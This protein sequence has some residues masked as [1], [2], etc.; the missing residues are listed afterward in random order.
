MDQKLDSTENLIFTIVPIFDLL[1][2]LIWIL[3]YFLS[4]KLRD[5]P[6]DLFLGMI[7]GEMLLTIHWIESSLNNKG[8]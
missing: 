5:P 8:K 3:V 6:G 2:C 1:I 7:F 4:K